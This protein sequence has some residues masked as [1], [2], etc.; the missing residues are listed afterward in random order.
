MGDGR[1]NQMKERGEKVGPQGCV[2]IPEI[3]LHESDGSHSTTIKVTIWASSSILSLQ[4]VGLGILSETERIYHATAF[5]N[6]C[7][8][9][10]NRHRRHRPSNKTRTNNTYINFSFHPRFLCTKTLPS[11]QVP[12]RKVMKGATEFDNN[13]YM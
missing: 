12:L 9:G 4:K 13:G 10:Q 3:L 11:C 2:C 5:S 6:V 8:S 1:P 7:K